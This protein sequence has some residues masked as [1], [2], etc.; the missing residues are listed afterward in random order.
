MKRMREDVIES[1]PRCNGTGNIGSPQDPQPCTFCNGS[2][3]VEGYRAA[4]YYD[5]NGDDYYDDDCCEDG[6]CGCNDDFYSAGYAGDPYDTS[7]MDDDPMDDYYESRKA[8]KKRVREDA[9]DEG[10]PGFANKIAGDKRFEYFKAGTMQNQ[11]NVDNYASEV[12]DYR[13]L[14]RMCLKYGLRKNIDY[15]TPDGGTT[16]WFFDNPQDCIDSM[17]LIEYDDY[18]DEAPK[19]AVFSVSLY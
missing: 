13:E 10:L 8:S 7:F 2:G 15:Y 11:S 5:D 14:S 1:C 9:Y 16:Y 4:E 17:D 19:S 3:E 6:A 18:D 12:V